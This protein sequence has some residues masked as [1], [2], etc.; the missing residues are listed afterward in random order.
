M[1]NLRG[2]VIF[3]RNMSAEYKADILCYEVNYL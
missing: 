1:V 3:I 2:E